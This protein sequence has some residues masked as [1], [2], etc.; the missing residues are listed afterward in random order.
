MRTIVYSYELWAG[1]VLKLVRNPRAVKIA[2]R[3][4]SLDL[5]LK[6]FRGYTNMDH[7]AHQHRGRKYRQRGDS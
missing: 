2:F 1:Q 4:W 7:S 6:N 5:D 3:P